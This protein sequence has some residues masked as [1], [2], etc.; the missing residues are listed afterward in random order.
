MKPELINPRVK[1]LRPEVQKEIL[2]QPDIMRNY[3]EEIS[4]ELGDK[5][6]LRLQEMVRMVGYTGDL[7]NREMIEMWLEEFG[8]EFKRENI[9]H[10]LV[11]YSVYYN[12]NN[13]NELVAYFTESVEPHDTKEFT[14]VINLSPIYCCGSVVPKEVNNKEDK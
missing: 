8:L 7:Q 11:Q 14:Y 9:G 12:S 13:L 1:T 6:E 3:V 4:K 10:N 5:L 2:E